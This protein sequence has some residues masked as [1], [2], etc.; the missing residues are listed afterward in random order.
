MWDRDFLDKWDMARRIEARLFCFGSGASDDDGGGGSDDNDNYL[1]EAGRGRTTSS[2]APVRS[3]APP[4]DDSPDPAQ[5]I[6]SVVG[7]PQTLVE[8]AQSASPE[9]RAAN[10]ARNDAIFNEYFANDI[11]NQQIDATLNPPSQV[12]DMN[13]AAGDYMLNPSLLGGGASNISVGSSNFPPATITDA[14]GTTFDTTTGEVVMDMGLDVGPGFDVPSVLPS[15]ATEAALIDAQ[16]TDETVN[17]DLYRQ[18]AD[19]AAARMGLMGE[20]AKSGIVGADADQL[21]RQASQSRS[22]M[23]GTP[24]MGFT[25]GQLASGPGAYFAR[26]G[27]NAPAVMEYMNSSNPI[28]NVLSAITGLNTPQEDLRLGLGQPVFNSKGKIMGE[29]STNALGGV[30]YGGNRFDPGPDHPFRDIIAPG[31][32]YGNYDSS[33]EDQYDMVAPSANPLTGAEQCP[34][35]YIYDDFLQACRP[36]TRSESNQDTGGSTGTD[37]STNNDSGV[38]FRRTSLDDAPANLPAGFGFDAANRRFTESYGYR[39]DFYRS[40]MSLTGFTRLS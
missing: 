21:A 30:V 16:A 22:M 23:V 13:D 2:P 20:L 14:S 36:K 38:F 35:G 12:F 32:G 28:G 6:A 39:P 29:L 9:V 33:H 26:Y 18:R 31:P 37:G 19:A 11:F 27:P 24:E 10:S 8:V 7:I 15:S 34:D 40:P 4:Q 5:K 25:P 3:V 1:V 17:A